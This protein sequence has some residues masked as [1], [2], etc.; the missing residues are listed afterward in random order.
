MN[1]LLDRQCSINLAYLVF[2]SKVFIGQVLLFSD[3]IHYCVEEVC[4]SFIERSN[5]RSVGL[6]LSLAPAIHWRLYL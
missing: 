1:E 5:V 6:V 4:A 2:N 3:N